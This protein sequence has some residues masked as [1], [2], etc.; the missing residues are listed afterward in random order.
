MF[1]KRRP[2]LYT[3]IWHVRYIYNNV[4]EW[5]HNFSTLL[6]DVNKECKLLLFLGILGIWHGYLSSGKSLES[7]CNPI[8]CKN[9]ACTNIWTPKVITA[10]GSRAEW[11]RSHSGRRL[12]TT[13][14]V[15]LSGCNVRGH[16]EGPREQK[17]WHG[18]QG[19]GKNSQGVKAKEKGEEGESVVLWATCAAALIFP[20]NELQEGLH[21]GTTGWRKQGPCEK[22]IKERRVKWEKMKKVMQL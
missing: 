15:C 2:C 12:V 17:R 20:I 9:V 6:F 13:T 18:R 8:E 7:F 21:V 11:N 16:R 3:V 5:S 14:S 1:L 19:V 22:G 4:F 10:E